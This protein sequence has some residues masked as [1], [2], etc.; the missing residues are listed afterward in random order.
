MTSKQMSVCW[1]EAFAYGD[2]DA[3]VSDLAL[4]SVWGDDPD[5]DIPAGR[6]ELLRDVY[7]VAHASVKDLRQAAGLTQSQLAVRF[8]IPRRTVEN[9]EATGP[10]ARTCP[11]YVRR[12]MAECLGLCPSGIDFD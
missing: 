11:D 1:S 7:A 6:I 8:G 9:W 4:S 3:Y 5:G 10:N 2:V 12:M